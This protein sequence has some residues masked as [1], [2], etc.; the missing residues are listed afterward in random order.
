[1][2]SITKKQHFC[3]GPQPWLLLLLLELGWTF[4][5]PHR[6]WELPRVPSTVRAVWAQPQLLV[7]GCWGPHSEMRGPCPGWGANP[8]CCAGWGVLCLGGQLGT[9]QGL[10]SWAHCRAL[11]GS[12]PAPGGCQQQSSSVGWSLLAHLAPVPAGTPADAGASAQ[13]CCWPQPAAGVSVPVQPCSAPAVPPQIRVS[14]AQSWSTAGAQLAVLVPSP[15]GPAGSTRLG[16]VTFGSLL[17][18]SYCFE[19]PF[20]TAC[21]NTK[22]GKAPGDPLL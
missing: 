9:L 14:V 1:M 22:A 15:R 16:W 20:N 10:G 13:P 19:E 6:C 4:D 7:M 18:L 21:Q 8:L 3:S 2:K 11:Q 12:S 5:G 17:S